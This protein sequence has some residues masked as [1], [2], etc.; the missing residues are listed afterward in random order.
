[1][2]NGKFHATFIVPKDVSYAD[3]TARGRL[4]AY[5]YTPGVPAAD[6]VAYTTKV[7]IAGTDTTAVA[8]GEGPSISLYLENRSFRSGDM[9]TENPT[10]IV[11]LAD[12]AG[13]N[14]SG[15]GIGH[16]IE[17]WLNNSTQ[18]SDITDYYT[19][20]LDNY[21]EGTIQYPLKK[22]PLGRN[23]LRV[24]AWDSFNNSSMVE[25]YFTVAS[26]EGLTL[27]NV[28]NYPNPFGAETM[29]T[30]QQ[31]QATAISVTIRIYTVAGRLIQSLETTT[32]GESFVRI[33]WDGRDRD[34]DILANGVYLYKV[35]ARTLDGRFS[36]E[37]L[38]KLSV[39]R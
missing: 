36:S 2:N 13:I 7:R 19:S 14:T 24:R 3:S 35:V 16:R 4:V 10:L 22:L 38:G 11:D 1:V 20:K 12:S 26:G 27:A 31:N 18:S 23:S 37:A 33:P 25:T 34:G 29:F 5:Y 21:R 8:G 28:M 6:G 9:V 32:S 30:F 17:A 39:I 15:S